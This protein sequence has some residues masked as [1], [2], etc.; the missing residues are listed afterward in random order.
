MHLFKRILGYL[1]VCI[2]AN[3]HNSIDRRSILTVHFSLVWIRQRM[4]GLSRDILP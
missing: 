1:Y 2:T 4:Y 3:V